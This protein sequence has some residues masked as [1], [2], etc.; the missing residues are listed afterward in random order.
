[1]KGIKW[2]L[3]VD[4]TRGSSSAVTPPL[5]LDESG[6]DSVNRTREDT[7]EGSE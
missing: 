6:G 2:H 1:M 3:G 5:P 4:V 7:N